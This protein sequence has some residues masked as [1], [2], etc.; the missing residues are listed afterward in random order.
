M[1]PPGE[2]GWGSSG[3]SMGSSRHGSR[4]LSGVPVEKPFPGQRW[5]WSL[6]L[7]L[8]GAAA[9]GRRPRLSGDAVFMAGAS[10]AG[11]S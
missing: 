2:R 1:A 11:P 8:P 5:A 3:G 9:P 10:L 6:Q 7:S 4:C